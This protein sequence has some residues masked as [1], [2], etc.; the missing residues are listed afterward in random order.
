MIRCE[1]GVHTGSGY[2]GVSTNN[3]AE[4]RALIE[5]LRRCLEL[6]CK[7][8]RVCSDSEL[9]VRQLRGE[10]RVRSKNLIALHGEALELMRSF[11]SVEVVH[12]SREL[13]EEADRLARSAARVGR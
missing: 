12:V 2:V 5:G 9:L 3:V 1:D 11:E 10:Y 4:Y 8:V 13:N 7:R 6:G